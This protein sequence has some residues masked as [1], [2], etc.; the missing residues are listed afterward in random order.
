M[1]VI[2]FFDVIK[3]TLLFFCL[4]SS[5]AL[6]ATE[7]LKVAA[8]R[9]SPYVDTNLPGGGLAIDIVSAVF[10]RAGYHLKMSYEKWP[11]TLEGV[12]MGHYDIAASAWYSEQRAKSLDYTRAFLHNE[13]KF[14]VRSDSGIQFTDYGDLQGKLVG[15]VKKYAYGGDFNKANN[16][17]KLSANHVIQNIDSV[18]KGKIHATIA[19]ERVLIYKINSMMKHNKPLFTILPKSVSIKGLHVAVSKK[20]PKHKEIV[21]AF[22][23]ALIAM[24]EDGS[25]LKILKKH[26]SKELDW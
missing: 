1:S 5:S 9:W 19:D 21:A 24:K 23:K 4:I 26:Q 6:Y 16:F 14:L 25:Y 20:N 15:I 3:S 13:L 11:R 12:K 18:L 2:R 7:E 8:S 17:M 10:N 22:N